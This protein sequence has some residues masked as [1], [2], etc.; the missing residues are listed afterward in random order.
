MSPDILSV[1]CCG[2][3]TVLTTNLAFAEAVKIP[4]IK[5]KAKI[6]APIEFFISLDDQRSQTKR[7]IVIRMRLVRHAKGVNVRESVM[8]V[9]VKMQVSA[10]NEFPRSIKFRRRV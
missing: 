4:P 5:A 10:L 9:P 6:N 7:K 3:R 1:V 8:L 2:E